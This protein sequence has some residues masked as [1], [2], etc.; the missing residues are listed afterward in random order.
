[1]NP[2]GEETGL[3]S[4]QGVLTVDSSESKM[5]QSGLLFWAETGSRLETFTSE[6]GTPSSFL[7][8]E[9]MR[10]DFLGWVADKLFSSSS[11]SSLLLLH[12]STGSGLEEF[13]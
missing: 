8:V 9:K 11:S 5:E 6:L 4:G 7:L 1:M 2:A 3:T 12:S 10:T 13:F